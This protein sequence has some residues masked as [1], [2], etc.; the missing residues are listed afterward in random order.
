MQNLTEFYDNLDRIANN[1]AVIPQPVKKTPVRTKVQQEKPSKLCKP[2]E[3]IGFVSISDN[4]AKVSGV[5]VAEGTSV[6][7]GILFFGIL[8][9]A[10]SR[11]FRKEQPWQ[12][13]PPLKTYELEPPQAPKL[14]NP[15]KK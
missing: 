6:A 1:E 14:C 2:K 5:D 4:G 7:K 3:Y 11:F 10:V 8:F 9:L 15:C 12:S 13:L